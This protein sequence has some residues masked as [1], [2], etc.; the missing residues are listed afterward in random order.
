[1]PGNRMNR[2]AKYLPVLVIL[3]AVSIV[4]ADSDPVVPP[5]A[6]PP[7]GLKLTMAEMQA[8]VVGYESQIQTE[9][10]QILHLKDVATRQKDVIKLT[11]LNDKLIQLK[12]QMNMWD[13][14]RTQFDAA[15]AKTSDEQATAYGALVDVAK[16]IHTLRE[17]AN[18]C[19]GEPELFKQ[20]AGVEVNHPVFPDDPTVGD[21]F[22]PTVSDVEPPGYASPFF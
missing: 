3:G 2:F 1:L 14:G 22:D 10:R 15:T 9:H 5:A 8:G 7:A 16:A 4:A 20:E 6:T 13:S 18:G 19:V 11:C 17:E 12:A 21:P